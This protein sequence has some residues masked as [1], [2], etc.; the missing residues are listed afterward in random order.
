M[1][2]LRQQTWVMPAPAEPEEV[3][4]RL[5]GRL[6]V[7]PGTA[8]TFH[9]SWY[10]TF[11]WRLYR[12]GLLLTRER[13]Q[14]LLR[15]F[16]GLV[17]AEAVFRKRKRCLARD[18]PASPLAERLKR[19]LGVRALMELGRE[20][21]EVRPCRVLNRDRKMVVHLELEQVVLDGER[22]LQIRL[23]EV[24]GYGG[25]F[26]QVAAH[27]EEIGA[28]PAGD[29]SRELER[30]AAAG[31]RR[32]LDYSSAFRVE[33]EAD[34]PA[35]Q[36][37]LRIYTGLLETM[38]IN[39]PGV[40]EDIDSEF[41][42]DLRVAV[43]RTRSGLTLIRGV[44]DPQVNRRFKEEFGLIGR[45]TGPVRDLDVYLLAEPAYRAL[46]PERVHTGLDFFFEDLAVRRRAERQRLVRFL[47][48]QRYHQILDDWQ[49]VLEQEPP[50][51]GKKGQ[52]PMGELAGTMIRK[53]LER[54]LRDGGKI[55]ETSPDA[56]LHRLRIQCK[57]LRYSLEFFRSLYEPG[58]MNELIGQLKKLQNNLGDFN[59][60]SVQQEMLAADLDRLRP[61][62]R[63][64]MET[65]A[66]IGGLMSVLNRRHQ[67]VRARFG[68]TFSRFTRPRNQVLFRE[69]LG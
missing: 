56:Q 50:P 28:G 22:M 8:R 21:V 65:A 57:K 18:F 27:L 12:A 23:G 45:A 17:V 9:R 11:D 58:P 60:L 61:G 16:S 64:A 35:I 52:R 34:M 41:L 32:P 54:V 14:W 26:R 40:I 33:L 24:R 38:R 53:R 62:S 46:L 69:L 49:Q 48:G 6:T 2:P 43:R 68:R 15:D 20:A 25:R 19:L 31:G 5:A 36:A 10:D 44:L 67:R 3:L 4:A 7:E 59:D 63:R 55:S 39:E 37:V 66:A 30:V 29:W 13:G 1:Q 42:H 51:A 47:R